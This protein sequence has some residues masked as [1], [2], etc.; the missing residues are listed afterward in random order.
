MALVVATLFA[1]ALFIGDELLRLTVPE[2]TI[3]RWADR[4]FGR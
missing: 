2:E 1:L 3:D 4:I